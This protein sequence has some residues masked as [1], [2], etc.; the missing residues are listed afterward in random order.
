MS[1][2]GLV[3]CEAGGA[4]GKDSPKV[5]LHLSLW[6]VVTLAM[7]VDCQAVCPMDQYVNATDLLHQVSS[8]SF[9]TLT[10]RLQLWK[11]DSMGK[12]SAVPNKTRE[13]LGPWRH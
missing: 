11:M 8:V 5:G 9:D 2:I 4:P 12:E 13:A 6:N 7:T 10:Q 1:W 3:T